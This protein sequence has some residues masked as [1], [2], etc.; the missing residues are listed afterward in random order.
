MHRQWSVLVVTLLRTGLAGG[1]LCPPATILSEF[2]SEAPAAGCCLNFSGSTLGHVRWSWLTNQSILQILDLSNCNITSVEMSGVEASLLE[3]VYLGHNRIAALPRDFLAGQ[4]RLEEVDL[5]SNRLE[6]L[7]EGFLQDSDNL[8]SLHLQENQLSFLPASVLQRPALQSLELDGNPWDCSCSFLEVLENS[9]DTKTGDLVRNLTC[10]SPW[11]LAG[12]V[13][14]SVRLSDMCRPASLTALFIALPLLILSTLVVCWCCGRKRKE[15]LIL[16][17]SKKR[18]SG[19]HG[20][21]AGGQQMSADCTASKLLSSTANVDEEKEV[22]LGSVE[23]LHPGSCCSDGK[24]S[25][26]ELDSVSVS[27]VLKDSA[28]REKAYMT[29]STEYYSLVP[30]IQLDDSDHGE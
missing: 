16:G 25:R 7:P 27:E 5:S 4:P 9:K 3:K 8:R 13:V 21:P 26:S 19:S 18:T 2:P 12:R 6:E 20:P 11:K 17:S 14:W 15:A 23:S 29:Q 30:G 28:D 1:C 24:P 10:I 22:Q